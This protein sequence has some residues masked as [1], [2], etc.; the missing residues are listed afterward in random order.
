MENLAVDLDFLYL[1]LDSSGDSVF[2]SLNYANLLTRSVFSSDPVELSGPPLCDSDQV[3]NG[4]ECITQFKQ[5]FS[6]QHHPQLKLV[7]P[8][9]SDTFT[10][11]VWVLVRELLGPTQERIIFFSNRDA[12]EIAGLQI[13]HASGEFQF[14]TTSCTS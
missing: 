4:R 13:V 6:D 12:S 8:P 5:L 2:S 9:V 11:A 3:Y 1:G 14:L 10:A 7:I